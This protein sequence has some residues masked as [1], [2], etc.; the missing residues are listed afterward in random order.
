VESGAGL[1]DPVG[2]TREKVIL[3]L[4]LEERVN[5]V[6]VRGYCLLTYFLPLNSV[7][8]LSALNNMVDSIKPWALSLPYVTELY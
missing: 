2:R 6:R 5:L 7:R 3:Y 1:I 8:N 4:L